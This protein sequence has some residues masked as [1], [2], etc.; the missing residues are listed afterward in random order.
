M[1]AD[2]TR[3]AVDTAPPDGDPAPLDATVVRYRDEPDRCTVTP[4]GVGGDRRYTT[5][6]SVNADALVTLAEMR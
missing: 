2:T 5:W 4:R 6:L 3:D 1:S